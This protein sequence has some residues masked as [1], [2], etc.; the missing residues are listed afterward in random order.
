MCLVALGLI[1]ALVP[2]PQWAYAA[3]ASAP[4]AAAPAPQLQK[5]GT[6]LA[7]IT[8]TESDPMPQSTDAIT[9]DGTVYEL[10]DKAEGLPDA[11]YAA[12]TKT[13]AAR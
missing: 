1:V 11:S 12:P 6:A 3:G 7:E 13:Y 9:T 2:A 5:D 10:T 8:Y 4:T